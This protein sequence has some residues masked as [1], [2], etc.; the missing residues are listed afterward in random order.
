[1]PAPM[2]P[3]TLA[4]REGLSNQIDMIP[5]IMIVAT[6]RLTPCSAQNWKRVPLRVPMKSFR[7]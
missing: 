6:T 3:R 2:S 1:M 7:I 5:K 4:S